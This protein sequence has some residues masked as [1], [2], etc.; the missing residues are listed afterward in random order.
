MNI[1][2][3]PMQS[4]YWSSVRSIFEQGIKTRLATFEVNI[5]SWEDWDNNHL[6]I[7]RLVA[8]D[9]ERVIGWAALTT[10]SYRDVYFGV[11]EVSVYIA[12]EARSKGVGRILLQTLV[13]KSEKTV[14][15]LYRLSCFRNIKPA[16]HCMNHA[17][18]E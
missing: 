15:G 12:E 1:K 7:C 18:S 11:A 10:V 5:P 8:E 9:N 13:R 14:S 2:I 16:L 6:P 3:R 4:S 17:V